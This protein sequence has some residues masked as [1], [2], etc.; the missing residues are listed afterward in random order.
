MDSDLKQQLLEVLKKG[1]I[2]CE[3]ARN[4]GFKS[5][6]IMSAFDKGRD[7]SYDLLELGIEFEQLAE[8]LQDA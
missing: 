3:F 5:I 1:E 7:R 8:E 6:D 4:H 2:L